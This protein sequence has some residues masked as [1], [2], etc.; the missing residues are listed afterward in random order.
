MSRIIKSP[1]VNIDHQSHTVIPIKQI[2]YEIK[3]IP[4]N[5]DSREDLEAARALMLHSAREKAGEILET[6]RASAK[7]IENSARQQA[8]DE[9]KKAIA[10]GYAD[11][12]QKG[13]QDGLKQ[14]EKLID[15]AAGFIDQIK[16]KEDAMIKELEDELYHLA[17]DAARKITLREL[18]ADDETLIGIFDNVMQSVRASEWLILTLSAKEHKIAARNK[19]RLMEI[20]SGIPDFRIAADP[21]REEGV[22][23]VETAQA[24]YDAGVDAQLG[25]IS[26]IVDE[27][28]RGGTADP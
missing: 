8:Q 9:M 6:A 27:V 3:D 18:E 20:V 16:E 10:A 14:Y 28:R 15:T 11:G 24:I 21:D 23:V 19:K 17:L 12:L 1:K 5:L 26:E 2:S 25:A 13:R 4:E 7:D 22:I